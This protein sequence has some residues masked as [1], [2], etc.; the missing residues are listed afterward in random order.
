[1]TALQ[2]LEKLLPPPSEGTTIDWDAITVAYGTRF[3]SDYMDFLSTYGSGEIDGMLAIFAPAT[4]PDLLVRCVS[5][6]PVD[7]LDLPEIDEWS[8]T[9]QAELY[10]PADIMVWGE[11]AEADVLGWIT[12]N[13]EAD[14]W[15]VAVY[16]HGGE[17]TV[18]TCTMTGFLTRLLGGDFERNPTGLT[19]LYGRGNAQFSS[20]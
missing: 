3:P 10:D 1:M 9:H 14:D 12:V 16:T 2:R 17:W 5:R 8:D 19:R 13:D 11:T 6:L 20:S 7:V 15:P 18:F 4:D